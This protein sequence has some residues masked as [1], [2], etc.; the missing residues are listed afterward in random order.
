LKCRRMKRALVMER[1]RFEIEHLRA[2]N[3]GSFQAL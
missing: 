2:S 1:T 3:E